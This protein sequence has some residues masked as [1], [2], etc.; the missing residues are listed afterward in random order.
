MRDVNLP[1]KP[2]ENAQVW[3]DVFEAS[4]KNPLITQRI[5][6]FWI[7]KQLCESMGIKNI[8]DA[9]IDQMAAANMNF[10]V[11]PDEQIM[12]QAQAGNI[13]PMGQA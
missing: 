10:Q 2:S 11:T 12:N 8:D 1:L 5:D 9:R 3:A 7:F 13:V 4:V 6:I